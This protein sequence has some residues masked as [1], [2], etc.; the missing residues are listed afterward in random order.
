M[1]HNLATLLISRRYAADM[2]SRDS[3]LMVIGEREALAWVLRESRTAFPATRRPEV[4]QLKAGDELFLLTTRGCF[5]NPGR[6]RTRVIG[7]ANVTT[8]VLPLDPPSDLVGRTRGC[9]LEIT[10]LA[11]Y[12]TG[13]ELADFVERLDAFPDKDHWSIRLR[14]P[15]V[16]LSS[17]DARLLR[18]ALQKVA[19]SRDSTAGT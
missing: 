3:Y 9:S 7:H 13:V 5:H 11:P 8:D 18:N 17:N 2:D 15:L 1:T 19:G 6:D 10:S 16:P 4:D 14:R 12:L